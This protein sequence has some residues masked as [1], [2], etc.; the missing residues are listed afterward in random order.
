MLHHGGIG[1]L[2]R[3]MKSPERD[4]GEEDEGGED[5]FVIFDGHRLNENCPARGLVI[6]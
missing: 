4:P 5:T 2:R 1:F 6:V 3:L